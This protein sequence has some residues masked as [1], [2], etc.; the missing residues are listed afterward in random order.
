MDNVSPLGAA[1][2]VLCFIV[3]AIFGGITLWRERRPRPSVYAFHH[4]GYQATRR[5]L[6]TGRRATD[7]CPDP[8][9]R[10][11][12]RA[13]LRGECGNL[14][15]RVGEW[16][17]T[18]ERDIVTGS[19]PR[20]VANNLSGFAARL[21]DGQ[22]IRRHDAIPLCRDRTHRGWP[23]D[24]ASC[25]DCRDADAADAATATLRGD[26]SDAVTGVLLRHAATVDNNADDA[27]ST[28]TASA[29]E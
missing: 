22:P 16:N 10:M 19:T 3:A 23:G 7:L 14:S 27:Y 9:C 20:E 29:A 6:Y 28:R 1:L 25:P 21:Q 26:L 2:A 24:R 5:S 17:P 8:E 11:A 4:L 13:H 18:P 12:A 15:V